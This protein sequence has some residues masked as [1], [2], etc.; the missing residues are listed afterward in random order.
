[1]PDAISAKK[2]PDNDIFSNGN[3]P[4]PASAARAA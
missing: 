1:M 4:F 2:F 3:T